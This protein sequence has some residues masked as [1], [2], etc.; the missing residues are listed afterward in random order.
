MANMDKILEKLAPEVIARFVGIP[1]D[2]ARESYRLSSLVVGSF[3]EFKKE[4]TK[5]YQYQFGLIMGGA[6]IPVDFAE[7]FAFMI[8]ESAYG[9]MGGLS[10][11]YHIASTGIDGGMK[12]IL[13]T[14]YKQIKKQ[15]ID[16]YTEYIIRAHVDVL[17][18]DDKT[19]LMRQYLNKFR[20][21]LPRT[22]AM[23]APEWLAANYA[24]VIK[25]HVKMVASV[26]ARLAR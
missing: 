20:H 5:Y 17:D 9:S 13:D 26:C 23:K 10:G 18:W 25:Q 14:L 1:H 21:S 11:A 15:Q 4:V 8:L 16:L 24:D 12:D 22:F 19:E 7:G 2:L 6:H 3:D